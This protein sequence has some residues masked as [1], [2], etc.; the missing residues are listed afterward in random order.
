MTTVYLY[1]L[2][3]SPNPDGIEGVPWR[4]DERE[5]FFG[6]C[7]KRLR[8]LLRP[9]LLDRTTDRAKVREEIWLAGF[10]ATPRS[11]PRVRRLVWAGRLTEAM[12]FGRAWR[13]LSG[14][15]YREMR[16][17]PYTPVHLQPLEG[18]GQAVA[19]RHFHREHA[20][21]DAWLDDVMTPGAR[22]IARHSGKEVRLPTGLSWWDGFDRDICFLLENHF[23]AT[24]RGLDIDRELVALL[25][26]AQPDR[27]DVDDFAVFGVTKA[28]R[29][30]GRVGGHLELQGPHAERFVR[31]IKLRQEPS[32]TGTLHAVDP[33]K[34][35]T[36]C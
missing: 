32:R 5:V 10:N 21:A 30:D 35:R 11:G 29:A 3:A 1:I 17:H 34:A 7:K 8:S 31:W 33:G 22:R 6:P 20:G 13:D 19:Y 23:Y 16:D 12:S 18:D 9:R 26:A 15:R 24:G 36:R 2:G 4:V 25:R 14:P 28:G 27:R